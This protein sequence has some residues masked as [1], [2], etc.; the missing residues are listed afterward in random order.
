MVVSREEAHPAW[1]KEN[2]EWNAGRGGDV[3]SARPGLILQGT[4]VALYSRLLSR[5]MNR[6][7]S[8]RPKR[9]KMLT[10]VMKLHFRLY[11]PISISFPFRP[12]SSNTRETSLQNLGKVQLL[13]LIAEEGTLYPTEFKSRHSK[14]WFAFRD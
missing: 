8:Q 5:P 3:D 1:K 12:A 11:S 7:S 6:S 2:S 13:I 10:Y 9:V 4:K 14:L